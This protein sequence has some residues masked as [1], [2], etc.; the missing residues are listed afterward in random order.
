MNRQLIMDMTKTEMKKLAEEMTLNDIKENSGKMEK[1][2]NF[3]FALSEL[4]FTNEVGKVE[5]AHTNSEE[6][7][8]SEQINEEAKETSELKES[9]DGEDK[10]EPQ[11]EGYEFHR[12]M[13]G[14]FLP[15]IGVFVPETIIRTLGIEH[16]DYVQATEIGDSYYNGKK[17]YYFDLVEK[18]NKPPVADRVP[19]DYCL[20]EKDENMFVVKRTL[21]SGGERIRLNDA[22]YSFILRD[23]DVREHKIAENDIIDI[24]Y[25]ANDPMF[26][27]VVWKHDMDAEAGLEKSSNSGSS[28]SNQKKKVNSSSESLSEEVKNAF[29]GKKILVVG[30]EPRKT[31]FRDSI[32]QRGG[33]FYF[34]TGNE[35]EDRLES[36]IKKVDAVVLVI[37]FIRHRASTKVVELCKV[38]DVPFSDT[39]TLGIQS[40]LEGTTEAIE[41][42]TA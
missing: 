4:D 10:S 42:V 1:L 19:L 18:S 36:L 15:D 5:D 9:K 29:Q 41:Q 38:H 2:T 26:Y 16:G 39:K 13:K 22:P 24:A 31:V 11:K 30:C 3:L 25:S 34:A 12:K 20:V 14:G 21:M 33:E 17:K 23:D 37:R 35:E 27:K 40:L 28:A 32:E 7:N 8:R 6:F